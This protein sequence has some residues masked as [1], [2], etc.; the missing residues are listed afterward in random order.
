M[1][2]LPVGSEPIELQVVDTTSDTQLWEQNAFVEFFTV[3]DAVL[4][5]LDVTRLNAHYG[6]CASHAPAL[7]ALR[8]PRAT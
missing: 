7:M 1:L 6:A 3:V 2:K 8:R 4:I 5:V